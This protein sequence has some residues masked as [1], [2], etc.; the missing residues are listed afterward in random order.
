MTE[1]G[2][3]GFDLKDAEGE[4]DIVSRLATLKITVD[5]EGS[6]VYNLSETGTNDVLCL[7]GSYLATAEIIMSCICM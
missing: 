1:K 4:D 6:Y 5:S 7:P 2:Y 3:T